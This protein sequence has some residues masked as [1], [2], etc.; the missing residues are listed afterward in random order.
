MFGTSAFGIGATAN[1][2]AVLSRPGSNTG[3]DDTWTRSLVRTKLESRQ[4]SLSART[5]SSTHNVSVLERQAL[6]F[7]DL[8]C[9]P[10]DPTYLEWC[11]LTVTLQGLTLLHIGRQRPTRPGS[12]S[13]GRRPP[14]SELLIWGEI[15]FDRFS[16]HVLTVTLFG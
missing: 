3:S 14:G 12:G 15:C 7:P 5:P 4:S 2:R 9:R 8:G 16:R 6:I 11:W 1:C 10:H 13:H